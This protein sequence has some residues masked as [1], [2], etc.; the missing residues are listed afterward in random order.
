LLARKALAGSV[1]VPAVWLLSKLGAPSLLRF[2]RASGFSTFDRTAGHYGLGLTLGDAEVRLD[3][4]VAGYAQF[5]NGG[6]HVEPHALRPTS[7]APPSRIM[8]ERSAFW[9]ADI[10]A[11]SNAREFIF[12][13][14]GSLD[15]P[16]PVSVK[17]GTSQA[18]RDNWTVGF[19]PEVTVGVWVGN[20]DRTPLRGSSGV[21][22]A[23]PVF[24][25]V[26]LAAQKRYATAP[27]DVVAPL[28]SQRVCALSGGAATIACSSV[29]EER[30]ASPRAACSW[31]QL[32]LVGGT[33]QSTV[34]YPAQFRQY[35]ERATG[36]TETPTPGNA[37]RVEAALAIVN[38]PDGASYSIDPTLRHEFQ[39]VRLRAAASRGVSAVTWQID[40]KTYRRASL[41]DVVRW[42][43]TRG[44]HRIDV[45]DDQGRR[46][47]HEIFVK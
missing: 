45:V 31:H 10:L 4:L 22:G 3:Q 38:P 5:A 35:V 24:H 6:V 1:N 23:A 27:K 7:G 11:D 36:T 34:E 9:I 41:A 26:M 28:A 12:G 17:T 14:G 21:T 29:I 33:T 44:P 47:R 30:V 37:K 39:T 25:S 15:F 8:S 13:S 18:Y 43:L 40:G 16:F 19:T 20:F 32:Q 46:A 42:P 2:L